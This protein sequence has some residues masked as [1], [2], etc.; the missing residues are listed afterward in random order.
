MSEI[1]SAYS[2]G[3]TWREEGGARCKSED[4]CR[5]DDAAHRGEAAEDLRHTL[6]SYTSIYIWGILCECQSIIYASVN[7]F[8]HL[9]ERVFV[10]EVFMRVSINRAG[11]LRNSRDFGAPP[12]VMDGPAIIGGKK[13]CQIRKVV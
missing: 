8:I 1:T 2:A 10:C 5:E 4:G 12:T 7:Q 3:P 6:Y 13:T 11:T 9:C